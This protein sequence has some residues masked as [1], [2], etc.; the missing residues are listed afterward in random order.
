MNFKKIVLTI[1][2]IGLLVGMSYFLAQPAL[3][4]RGDPSV[5]GPNCTPERH[6]AMIDAIENNDYQAWKDLMQGRGKISEVITEENFSRFTE[7]RKLR[8]EGKTEEADQIRAELGLGLGG[9]H[10]KGD[11]T[12]TGRWAR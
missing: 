7:M 11:G 12:G 10:Q 5:Q 1:S 6:E 2:G 3:A 8:H 9:R 4:Y